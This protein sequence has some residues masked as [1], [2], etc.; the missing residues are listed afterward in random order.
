[1]SPT[2]T[3]RKTFDREPRLEG[4]Q[5]VDLMM[6]EIKTRNDEILSI[7]DQCTAQCIPLR[8]EV[9][10]LVQAA[11]TQID[12][13]N[14]QNEIDL[15]LIEN[16]TRDHATELEKKRTKKL[17]FGL[18]KLKAFSRVLWPSGDEFA[19]L[20]KRLMRIERFTKYINWEPRLDKRAFAADSEAEKYVKF[21][22]GDD[23]YYE[24][25]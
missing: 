16:F 23:F 5:D 10:R 17:T 3:V 7:S 13:L 11:N 19:A 21:D 8:Q 25:F 12:A 15:K 2:Q 20:I 6:K 22:E 24:I 1:L 18:V 4:W 9:D 14:K